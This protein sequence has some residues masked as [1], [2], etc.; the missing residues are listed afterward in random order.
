M[1]ERRD[2]VRGLYPAVAVTDDVQQVFN[3]TSIDAVVIATPVATH[4]D[5]AI[6]ALKA[7]KHVLIEKPMARSV[8]EV[9]QI[10]ALANQKN[11]VAMARHTFV[12]NV[13]QNWTQ[14]AAILTVESRYFYGAGRVTE[15]FYDGLCYLH[16]GQ[17]L[18]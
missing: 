12:Y 5:L 14:E 1:Q 17:C 6:K 9:E 10:G 16:N 4:F 15:A 18:K 11:L 8:V 2:F 3:D 13:I 7:G